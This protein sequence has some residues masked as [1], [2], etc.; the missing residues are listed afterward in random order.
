MSGETRYVAEIA[1]II[2]RD[3]FK[4]FRWNVAALTDTNFDCVKSQEH[5]RKD[6]HTHPVDVVFYYDDP[7]LNWS[8]HR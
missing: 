5:S 7:Y 3:V 4:H 2:S 6:D 1:E 8:G